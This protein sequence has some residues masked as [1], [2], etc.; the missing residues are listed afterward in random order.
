MSSARPSSCRDVTSSAITWMASTQSGSTDQTRTAITSCRRSTLWR[1]TGIA[2]DTGN[3]RTT[4]ESAGARTHGAVEPS[5]RL[6]VLPLSAVPQVQRR[7]QRN[8][9]LGVA[10]PARVQLAVEEHQSVL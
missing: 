9:K 5:A 7:R 1:P 8:E 6:S 4:G 2:K 10:L 3:I